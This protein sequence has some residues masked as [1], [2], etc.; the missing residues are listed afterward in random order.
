MAYCD[1]CEGHYFEG[2]KFFTHACPPRWE[3]WSAEYDEDDPHK[4]SIYAHDAEAAAE[5]WGELDDRD[6]AEYS[7][8]NGTEAKCWVQQVGSDEVVK[9]AVS[10]EYDPMYYA[11]PV[12]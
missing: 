3:V 6:S 9:W 5:K 4:R 10:G 11:S 1:K 8:V 2:A 12:K 7:I